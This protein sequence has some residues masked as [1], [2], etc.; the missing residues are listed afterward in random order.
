MIFLWKYMYLNDLIV[1]DMKTLFIKGLAFAAAVAAMASCTKDA[2]E[3]EPAPVFPQLQS[4]TIQ[5]GDQQSLNFTAD[6]DWKLSIDKTT[7]CT[8]LDGEVETAQL[9][10]LKGEV[11]VTVLVKDNGLDFNSDVA[12]LDLTLGNKT[13][14]IFEITRPGKAREVKLYAAV[15][16]GELTEV[17]KLEFKWEISAWGDA[18][19]GQMKF[20]VVANYDWT[21]ATPEKCT[22]NDQNWN[23]IP[24][25]AGKAG[26]GPEDEGFSLTYIKVN[27]DANAY[28]INGKLIVTD[29][30][31]KNPVEFDIVYPGYPENK[32]AIEPASLLGMFGMNFNIDGFV[33]NKNF[34]QEEVTTDKEVNVSVKARN[35]E[36][37]VYQIANNEGKAVE[38]GEDAW[39]KINDDKK[40]GLKVSAIQNTGGDR[41]VYILVLPKA[42]VKDF[43]IEDFIDQYG[44]TNYDYD[45]M[46]IKVSQK[47]V[48]VTKDFK[49]LW[50]RTYADIKAVEFS[51][52]PDFKDMTPSGLEYGSCDD[53]AY[54][55][56]ITENDIIAH[57][58]SSGALQF[59]PLGFP[60]GYYAFGGTADSNLYRMTPQ[61]GEWD[62]K[63]IHDA[64]LYTSK[65][66]IHG[67]QIDPEQFV[68]TTE[69]GVTS[70]GLNG[71][72]VFQFY[73]TAED[74]QSY[75]SSATLV[76]VKK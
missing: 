29:T 28:E 9:S 31:G 59:A 23:E 2:T 13:E 68:N 39:L 56:E 43:K 41:E 45:G 38:L 22:F 50:G 51:K 27:E 20:A 53:N 24:G 63:Y 40:G 61:S 57:E 34:D 66:S 1:K 76:I 42:L 64:T 15:G 69:A 11:S 67:L 73:K 54:V 46:F 30:E 65:G 5:A 37:S 36:Y 52:Y 4:V 72:V 14:T 33:I 60:D 17:E 12:K 32:V 7:W 48:T 16:D 71:M 19:M 35:M 8:F 25:V 55:I 62:E 21:V 58:Q 75:K 3:E 49:A 70:K 18:Y 44:Y 47:G 26:V 10:G 74:K 6:K